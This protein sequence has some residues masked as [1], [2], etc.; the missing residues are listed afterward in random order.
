MF[1]NTIRS[2]AFKTIAKRGYADA[3]TGTLKLNFALPHE[4][5]YQDAVVKQVN[6]PAIA[7]RAGILAN[8]VPTVEELGAGLVEVFETSGEKKS[9]F[10]SGGVATVSPNSKISVTVVEAFPLDSFS[11]DAI[12]SKLAEAQKNLSSADAKVAAEA[13]IQVDVLTS[14]QNYAK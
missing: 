9:F 5:L 7:G 12:R 4:T 14:L 1:R 8:H 11:V 13:A 3:A 2:A 10:V 6:I